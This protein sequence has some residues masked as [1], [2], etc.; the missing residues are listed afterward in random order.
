[1]HFF[2]ICDGH[3]TNGKLVSSF[4]KNEFPKTF[5]QHLETLYENNEFKTYPSSQEI[6]VA[7]ELTFEEIN[8]RL[9]TCPFDIQFSGST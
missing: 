8:N 6:K 7:L 3:G 1:M 2:G 4:I 9:Y 5:G